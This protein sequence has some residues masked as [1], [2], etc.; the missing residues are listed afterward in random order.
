VASVRNIDIPGMVALYAPDAVMLPPGEAPRTS[1]DA[2]RDY[3]TGFASLSQLK[4]ADES[5]TASVSGDLGYTVN[6][7]HATF[8]DAQGKPVS[9]RMRDVHVWRKDASGQ[10]KIVMDIWNSPPADSGSAQ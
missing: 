1:V 7:I 4:M 3:V 5:Q 6:L 8:V 10:W 9:E 2:I